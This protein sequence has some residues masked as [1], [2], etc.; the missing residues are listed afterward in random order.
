MT[1]PLSFRALQYAHM[2]SNRNIT[3][4]SLTT[5]KVSFTFKFSCIVTP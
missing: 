2:F 1:E 4:H 3:E 5:L